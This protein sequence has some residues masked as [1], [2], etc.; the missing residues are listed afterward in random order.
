MSEPPRSYTGRRDLIADKLEP[1]FD[2]SAMLPSNIRPTSEAAEKFWTTL[3]CAVG[4]IGK[5]AIPARS[6]CRSIGPLT[7]NS[8]P[9]RFAP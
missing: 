6:P 7:A 8:E 4:P 2:I 3:C 9:T 5:R 1:Y